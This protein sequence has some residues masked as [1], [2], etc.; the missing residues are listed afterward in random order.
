MV[1][2]LILLNK[3]QN[4][5]VSRNKSGM[6]QVTQQKLNSNNIAESKK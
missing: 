4:V 3:V 1:S 5:Q 2:S 6:K